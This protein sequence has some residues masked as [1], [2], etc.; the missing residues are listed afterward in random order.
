MTSLEADPKWF[1]AAVIPVFLVSCL[2]C[3][4]IF[5]KS[6]RLDDELLPTEIKNLLHAMPYSQIDTIKRTK[7][8][9]GHGRPS[10]RQARRRTRRHRPTTESGISGGSEGSSDDSSS[11][12]PMYE[13]VPP[14][15]PVVLGVGEHPGPR[16]SVTAS[17][18]HWRAQRP[19]FEPRRRRR[20]TE[21][22]TTYNALRMPDFRPPPPHRP[23]SPA[24]YHNSYDEPGGP[25]YEYVGPRPQER[26]SSY[27][28][29]GVSEDRD[30]EGYVLRIV[31]VE[32][33]WV[34]MTKRE[35][36]GKEHCLEC[37][38]MILVLWYSLVGPELLAKEN[39]VAET[40][41][42]YHI[43]LSHCIRASGMSSSRRGKRS[44]RSC[45][46]HVGTR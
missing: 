20:R 33:W 2:L 25:S 42:L 32:D 19:S 31:A 10:R 37:T 45:W 26:R 21:S 35:A 28:Q 24:G 44:Y 38:Y 17:G 27:H 34:M 22:S 1:A 15:P 12:P 5:D 23:L 9:S 43:R 36:G 29:P 8:Y 11:P 14:P 41:E 6:Q 40:T 39:T 46:G 4:Y 7:K 13:T 16:P 3:W 30:E 18:R